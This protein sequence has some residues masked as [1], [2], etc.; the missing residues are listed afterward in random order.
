MGLLGVAV[1]GVDG[2]SD[3]LPVL[4]TEAP[5]VELEVTAAPGVDE[6]GG[7]V[8]APAVFADGHGARVGGGGGGGG[9]GRRHLG[10]R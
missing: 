9:M 1:K 4:L 3:L 6:S 2:V 10:V 5:A 8:F 7:S